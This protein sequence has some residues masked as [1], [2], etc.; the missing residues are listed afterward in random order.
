MRQKNSNPQITKSNL[1]QATISGSLSVFSFSEISLW[2]MIIPAIAW[3]LLILKEASQTESLWIGWFFGIGYFGVNIWWIHI[4]IESF[5]IPNSFIAVSINAIFICLLA[6]YF[7]IF[8]IL[9]NLLS[10]LKM[11][12]LFIPPIIWLLLEIFRGYFLTG[13]PWL[14]VGYTQIDSP[15]SALFPLIGA[16]GVSF[17]I[18]ILA[19]GLVFLLISKSLNQK[20]LGVLTALFII[21]LSYCLQ[22]TEYTTKKGELLDV[23]IVQGSLPYDVR[24]S[25][26][27]TELIFDQYMELSKDQWDSDILVWPETVFTKPLTLNEYEV[28][29]LKSISLRTDTHLILGV[30]FLQESDDKVF[31]SILSIA[32]SIQLYKKRKLV[33]FGEYFPL[34]K[35]FSSFYDTLNVP[36]SDFTQGLSK[37]NKFIVKE[38]TIGALICYE[39]AFASIARSSLPQAELIVNLSN[40]SWFGRSVAAFQHLQIVR[41][42]AAE[43][44]R[45]II[46]ATNT[47]ISAIIDYKGDVI[48][49]SGQFEAQVIS[50]EI[51]GRI[52]STPYAK[53]GERGVALFALGLVVFV[54]VIRFFGYRYIEPQK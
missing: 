35:V 5:G 31:N 26:S 17:V 47:G 50:G 6:I 20:A 30:P 43:L 48:E 37:K 10:L 19:S 32:D 44:E 12:F 21:A 38:N 52:G 54:L 18:V 2:F 45:P 34:R 8:G 9:V 28:G 40:D 4:S 14:V 13:F 16:H 49:S 39:I 15:F 7:S 3:F 53:I 46:R 22:Q 11:P 51:V 25:K 29:L 33:P 36:L 41:V 42:R 1:I 23:S 24:W 27:S